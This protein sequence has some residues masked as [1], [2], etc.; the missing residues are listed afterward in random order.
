[1][2]HKL[3]YNAPYFCAKIC[4][5][6]CE[7][8]KLS[9]EILGKSEYL[10]A[11]RFKLFITLLFLASKEECFV[12]GEQLKRGELVTTIKGLSERVSLTIKQVRLALAALKKAGVITTRSTNVHTVVSICNFDSYTL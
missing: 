11:A 3:T 7:N 6:M 1:M 2:C 8:I 9:R 10:Y 5:I 4:W 12:D